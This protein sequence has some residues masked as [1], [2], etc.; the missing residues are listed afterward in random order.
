MVSELLIS[1]ETISIAMTIESSSSFST[2]ISIEKQLITINT[3]GQ[4]NEELIPA[5][6]RQW[7]AQFEVLFID[8]NLMNF[9]I[10]TPMSC[11]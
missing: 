5:T 3:A 1:N 7:R 8:Y 4:I 10:G 11:H 6:F 2:L 9:V